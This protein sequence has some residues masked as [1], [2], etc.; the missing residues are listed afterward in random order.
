MYPRGWEDPRFGAARGGFPV[1]GVNWHEAN[2]YCRWLELRWGEVAEGQENP[3]LL[4][5]QVRLPTSAE[6]TLAAGG[7]MPEGRYPWYAGRSATKT[8]DL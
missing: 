8:G 7:L 6:W 2:A 3:G 1:V 4:P 5:R